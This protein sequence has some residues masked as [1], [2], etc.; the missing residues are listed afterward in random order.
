M[1]RPCLAQTILVCLLVLLNGCGRGKL[2]RENALALLRGSGQGL[3]GA[4][5]FTMH[6]DITL[7][8]AEGEDRLNTLLILDFLNKLS[9]QGVLRRPQTRSL[10]YGTRYFYYSRPNPDIEESVFVTIDQQISFSRY[11]FKEITGIAEEGNV[12]R[13]EVQLG[14]GTTPI[15]KTITAALDALKNQGKDL[16]A[17]KWVMQHFSLGPTDGLS[18]EP[19]P[20][21]T[22]FF[23]KYDDGWRLER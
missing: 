1:K 8:D 10:Y 7:P 11:Y 17:N 4:R 15:F 19:S 2:T 22:V 18:A 6:T 9:E 13:V 14:E 12:A 3:L 20:R 16:R 5:S 21:V 23:R